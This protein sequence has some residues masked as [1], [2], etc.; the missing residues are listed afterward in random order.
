MQV[1]PVS[2]PGSAAPGAGRRGRRW[3]R[4]ALVL[5]LLLIAYAAALAWAAQ[6]LERDVLQNFHPA[7]AVLRADHAG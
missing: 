1:V 7:P 4:V 2:D 3:W 5:G 6:R